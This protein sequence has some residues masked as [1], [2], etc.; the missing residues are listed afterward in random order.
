MPEITP[1][2]KRGPSDR[3]ILFLKEIQA[4]GRV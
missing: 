1:Q 3:N 4:D 2:V